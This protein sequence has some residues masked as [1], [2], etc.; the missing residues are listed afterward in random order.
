MP[1]HAVTVTNETKEQWYTIKVV[2]LK[3]ENVGKKATLSISYTP[4]YAGS[5]YSYLLQINGGEENNLAWREKNPDSEDIYA[6]S[7]VD[8]VITQVETE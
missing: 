4:I 6:A 2:P 3:P 1:D 5:E 8:V 7:T